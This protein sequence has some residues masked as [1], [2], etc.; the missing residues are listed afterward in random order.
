M[1][2][3]DLKFDP[4]A[5]RLLLAEAGYP[6]GEGFP[7]TEILYNT[8]EAHRKIAVAIQQMWKKYLNIDVTLLNQEWKVFLDNQNSGDFQISRRGW[9]GDYMDPNVFLGLYICN[10]GNN[11]TGWCNPEFDHLILDVAPS[12]KSQAERYEAFAKAEKII[13]DDMPTIPIYIYTANNL[14]DPAVKGFPYNILN[15]PKFKYIYLQND[16]ESD[17][18]SNATKK[19]VH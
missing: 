4:E 5:A 14:M 10:G 9:I 6:N 7:K 18:N 11:N 2:Q 12:A 17:T 1:P 3:S 13:L 16:A 19:E 15:E 8:N